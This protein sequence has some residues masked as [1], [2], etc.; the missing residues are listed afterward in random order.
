V[1]NMATGRL[2]S[3]ETGDTLPIAYDKWVESVGQAVDRPEFGR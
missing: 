1:F 2:R 3:Q